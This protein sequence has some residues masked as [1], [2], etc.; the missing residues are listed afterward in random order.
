MSA[1][2][3]GSRVPFLTHSLTF[4]G[5]TVSLFAQLKAG[6]QYKGNELVPTTQAVV[7]NK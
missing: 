3:W 1:H 7:N 2:L 4:V 6:F 5:S